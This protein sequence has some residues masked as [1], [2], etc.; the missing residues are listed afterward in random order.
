MVKK[1]SKATAKIPDAELRPY[2]DESLGEYL[3][4]LRLIRNLN[5]G[6]V[7]A[8]TPQ[9]PESEHVS[10]SYLSQLELGRAL[11]PSRERL[12]SLA[13]VLDV[14]EGWI[15]EKAGFS[16]GN[17]ADAADGLDAQSRKIALRAAQLN[18]E[19]RTLLDSMIQGILHARRSRKRPSGQE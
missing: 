15:L 5:L 17:A 8:Q 6:A 10:Q 9:V 16:G 11:K 13:R 12:A 18:P 2:P 1:D 7:C 3:R 19:E 4:R 14:P